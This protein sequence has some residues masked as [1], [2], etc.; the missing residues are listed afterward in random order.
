MPLKIW[1]TFAQEGVDSLSYNL[2]S[3]EG[4]LITKTGPKISV[5]QL[6]AVKAQHRGN[7]TCH[8]Q[9]K[10]GV[11]SQSSYLMINGLK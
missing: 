3:N 1:W 10:A 9:N 4:V 7:Y 6:D 2:T 5:L 11:S 8:A